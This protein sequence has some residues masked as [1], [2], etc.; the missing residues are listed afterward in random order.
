MALS[1]AV[2]S[3]SVFLWKI[4]RHAW[5]MGEVNVHTSSVRLYRDLMGVKSL[6]CNYMRSGLLV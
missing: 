5:H 1:C 2:L 4:D 3:V 6:R